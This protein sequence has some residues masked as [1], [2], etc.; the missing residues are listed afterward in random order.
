[1][2][3]LER[4]R[5]QVEAASPLPW[6]TDTDTPSVLRDATGY[7]VDDAPDPSCTFA[8]VALQVSSTRLARALCNPGTVEILVRECFIHDQPENTVEAILNALAGM[9]VGDE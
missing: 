2:T 4:L 3:P 9:G 7:P 8:N 1:M 5:E 6:S